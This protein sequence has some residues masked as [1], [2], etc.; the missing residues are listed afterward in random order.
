MANLV[1]KETTGPLPTSFFDLVD[2]DTKVGFV[3]VRHK[4]SHS[5]EVPEGFASHIYYEIDPAYRDKGYGME[6]LRLALI[7]ARK[8]NL[9]EVIV[10]CLEENAAS[11]RII[12]AN[13]GVFEEECFTM[14]GKKFLK[15]RVGLT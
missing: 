9:Q 11:R 3:Q 8:L 4:P 6:I 1:F 15:Y 2:G 10:T 14:N 12:E 13:G 5:P 7:E